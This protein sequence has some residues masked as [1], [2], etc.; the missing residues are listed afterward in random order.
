[1]QV[2]QDYSAA[3]SYS[4]NTT[5]LATGVWQL[6]VYVRQAGSTVDKDAYAQ[7]QNYQLGGSPCSSVSFTTSPASPQSVGTVVTINA[8]STGCTS[9][10][11]KYFVMPPGGAWQ[12]AQDYSAAASFSWNTAGLAAGVWQLD[13]YVRQAGSLADKE[14]YAQPQNFQLN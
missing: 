1:W 8:S 4:W 13:V 7:P 10:T 11:Y 6:D 9:P 3:A 14:A 12:V 5:G 2:A